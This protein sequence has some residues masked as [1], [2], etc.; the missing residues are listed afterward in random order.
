MGEPGVVKVIDV[1][2]GQVRATIDG[3]RV[4]VGPLTEQ[5]RISPDGKTLALGAGSEIAL[6]NTASLTPKAPLTAQGDLAQVAFSADSRRLAA[7]D[8]GLAVW[9]I[10]RP[11]PGQLY[12]G[13]R[14]G[15]EHIELSPDGQTLYSF[16]Q[17]SVQSWDIA[18]NPGFLV[19]LPS[20]PTSSSDVGQDAL[21]SPDGRRIA[22]TYFRGPGFGIEVRDVQSGQLAPLIKNDQEYGGY[23]DMDCDRMGWP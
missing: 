8:S 1:A 3:P 15:G 20:P 11:N 7:V 21:V 10:T 9:D 19:D 5:M 18:G 17:T 22:Y 4:G 23:E 14:W 12:R 13:N 2:G 6:V 16:G